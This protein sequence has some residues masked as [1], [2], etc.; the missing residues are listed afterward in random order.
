MTEGNLKLSGNG[1]SY[2]GRK[3]LNWFRAKKVFMASTGVLSVLRG[4]RSFERRH[5]W[6]IVGYSSD[7]FSAAYRPR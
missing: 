7:V 2:S 3:A 5:G 1:Q 6:A 4:M